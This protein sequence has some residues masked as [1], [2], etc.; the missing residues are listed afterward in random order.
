MGLVRLREVFY[1]SGEVVSG[2][3][4]QT[5]T[6]GLGGL[7]P[8]GL[9]FFCYITPEDRSMP[10]LI[11]AT[12]LLLAALAPVRAQ[13]VICTTYGNQTFCNGTTGTT[14]TCTTINNMTFCN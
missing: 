11:L 9:I 5:V 10:K 14:L 7:R 8:R 6:R 12:L 1:L 4:P 13:S 2:L 3:P